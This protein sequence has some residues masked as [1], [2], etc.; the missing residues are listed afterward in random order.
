MMA[1]QLL[2]CT[3]GHI[4]WRC[5]MCILM[6]SLIIDMK[7]CYELDLIAA[8]ARCGPKAY[9]LPTITLTFFCI[10]RVLF[11]KVIF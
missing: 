1:L 7:Q 2:Q 5:D 8:R 6:G 10:V 3:M 11:S 9:R 4:V